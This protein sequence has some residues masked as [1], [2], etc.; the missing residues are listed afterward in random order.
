V[1]LQVEYPNI[2][3]REIDYSTN[4][5]KDI[6]NKYF[7]LNKIPFHDFRGGLFYGYLFGL[8]IAE[9]RY[10]IH[11]DAN[12]LF[13][14]G[15]ATWVREAIDLLCN[16]PD[17]VTCSPLSGPPTVDGN[18]I[19]QPDAKKIGD[20]F[21]FKFSHFSTRVYF[22]DKEKFSSAI[23]PLSIPRLRFRQN[24]KATLNGNCTCGTLE[25]AISKSMH[26]FGLHRVDFL[27]DG[28]GM[29]SLHP[30]TRTN[31]FYSKLQKVIKKVEMGDIAKAQL[32]RYNLDDN[33]IELNTRQ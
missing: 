19:D 17:V 22:L 30:T 3:M 10:I 29:W 18:L 1:Q 26:E 31:L 13:G 12:M 6:S 11:L 8:H 32:G 25:M 15:S 33:L 16:N 27:G 20:L 4:I 21:K 9:H 7:L 23:I 14:G 5:V 28:Q 24:I 2:S